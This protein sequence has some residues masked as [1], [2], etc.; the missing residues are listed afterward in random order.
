MRLIDCK[1]CGKKISTQASSCPNCGAPV[2]KKQRSSLSQPKLIFLAVAIALVIGF[3]GKPTNKS[4]IGN[5]GEETPDPAT[6]ERTNRL[7]PVKIKEG[8]TSYVAAREEDS[9]LQAFAYAR[10]QD[11]AGVDKLG[12][13]GKI[14]PIRNGA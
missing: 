11:R 7:P 2:K 9:L 4:H 14:F 5:Q 3:F 1:A 13:L 12:E 8:S 10:A 6:T